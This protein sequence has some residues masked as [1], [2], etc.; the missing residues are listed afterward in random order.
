MLHLVFHKV[1]ARIKT[2]MQVSSVIKA[3][4]RHTLS[5]ALDK[6]WLPGR[7]LS[8]TSILPQSEALHYIHTCFPVTAR[9]FYRKK[10]I[11]LHYSRFYR[12]PDSLA[13]FKLFVRRYDKFKMPSP[14]CKTIQTIYTCQ[15][16]RDIRDGTLLLHVRHVILSVLKIPLILLPTL[17]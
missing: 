7:C 16:Y 17:Q 15:L 4:A 3:S 5:Y 9:H 13:N 12:V 11:T 8:S 6:I 1:I 14:G 10:Q 2:L